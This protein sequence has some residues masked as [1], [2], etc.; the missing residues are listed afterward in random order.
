LYSDSAVVVDFVNEQNWN[1]IKS[2][3]YFFLSI[4]FPVFAVLFT[5]RYWHIGDYTDQADV[6]AWMKDYISDDWWKRGGLRI[7]ISIAS[8]LACGIIM[9][10]AIWAVSRQG[11][12]NTESLDPRLVGGLLATCASVLAILW[13]I[14]VLGIKAAESAFARYVSQNVNYTSVIILKRVVKSKLELGFMLMLLLF[15]PVLYMLSQSITVITN[16]NETLVE[17]RLKELNFYTSCFFGAFPP[18]RLLRGPYEEDV[19]PSMQFM[20]PLQSAPRDGPYF[21]RDID[22]IKCDALIGTTLY[23]VGAVSMVL[24]FISYVWIYISHIELAIRELRS[25][26][27]M[28]PIYNL[29]EKITVEERYYARDFPFERRFARQ[30]FVE[31]RQQF[32]YLEDGVLWL[33]ETLYFIVRGVL[34]ITLLPIIVIYVP[35]KYY[36]KRLVVLCACYTR[37][38]APRTA[39]DEPEMTSRFVKNTDVINDTKLN[40]KSIREVQQSDHGLTYTYAVTVVVYRALVRLSRRLKRSWYQ[41]WLG[42][43]QSDVTFFFSNLWRELTGRNKSVKDEEGLTVGGDDNMPGIALH[44]WREGKSFTTRERALR[45]LNYRLAQEF[46][47]AKIEFVTDHTMSIT[48]FDQVI[49]NAGAFFLVCPFKLTRLNYAIVWPFELCLYAFLGVYTDYYHTWET[50][51]VILICISTSMIVLQYWVDP[52]SAHED[53]WIDWCGRVVILIVGLGLLLCAPVSEVHNFGDSKMGPLRDFFQQLFA[54]P[55]SMGFYLLMDSIMTASVLIFALS[56][57]KSIGVFRVLQTYIDGVRYAMHD[58]V[59]DY[60]ML[61]VEERQFGFENMNTGLPLLMQWDDILRSQ[62]RYAL[63]TW[64][65]VRPPDLMTWSEKLII[66]KWAALFNLTVPKMRTT[67]GLSLLHTAMYSGDIAATRYLIYWYP[68]MLFLEDSQRDT[69]LSIGLK[70]CSFYLIMFSALNN[71][72][73][74][75]GTSFSDEDL[76]TYYPEAEAL[77]DML[78]EYGE[79]V[80]EKT[81]VYTLTA[82]DLEKMRAT[83]HFQERRPGYKDPHVSHPIMRPRVTFERGFGNG[84]QA[85]R[86]DPKEFDSVGIQGPVQMKELSS[87]ELR[88]HR[89]RMELLA[90]NPNYIMRYPEDSKSNDFESGV[91][92]CWEVLDVVVPEQTI[93]NDEY[94]PDEDADFD[95]KDL[96]YAVEADAEINSV[97]DAMAIP[98]GHEALLRA[99]WGAE[100]TESKKGANMFVSAPSGGDRKLAY[101]SS[102]PAPPRA[103]RS[104]EDPSRGAGVMIALKFWDS[105]KT[106]AD[107]NKTLRMKLCNFTDMFMADAVAS[108]CRTLTWK[109]AS[110]TELNKMSSVLQGIVAQNLAECFNLNPPKGFA[111]FNEWSSGRIKEVGSDPGTTA[112]YVKTSDT[113]NND[114]GFLK[115]VGQLVRRLRSGALP[116]EAFNDRI[117]MYLAEAYVASRTKLDLTG[118][119]MSTHARIAWRGITRAL[120]R[121]YNSFVVPSLFSDAKCIVLLQL[122]LRRNELDDGDAVLLGDIIVHQKQL[123]YIDVSEN[124]IGSR[125]MSWLCSCMKEHAS[126]KTFRIDHNRVGPACGRDV[127]L[128]LNRSTTIETLSMSHNRMGDL[129]RYP[130]MMTRER[131]LSAAPDIFLGVKRNKSLISLDLSYNYLGPS[132]ANSAPAAVIK[133]PKLQFLNLAGNAIGPLKGP[134]LLWALAG[135]AGGQKEFDA[136]GGMAGLLAAK[137]A[138]LKDNFDGIDK[139]KQPAFVKVPKVMSARSNLS[140]TSNAFSKSVTDDMSEDFGQQYVARLMEL[141]LSDNQ[142]GAV[143]GVA[144]GSFVKACPALTALDVSK[145]ALGADGCQAFADSLCELYLVEAAKDKRK[146]E[147]DSLIIQGKLPPRS[148]YTVKYQPLTRADVKRIEYPKRPP[149]L[150]HL[151]ISRNNMLPTTLINIMECLM[152]PFC[153]VTNLDISGNNLGE[154]PSVSNEDMVHAAQS[155]RTALTCNSV[156]Y[157]LNVTEMSLKPVHSVSV[158]GGFSCCQYVCEFRLNNVFFDEPTCLQLATTI[159]VCRSLRHLE[160]RNGMMGA[161]GGNLICAQVEKSYEYLEYVDLTGNGIGYTAMLPI[162]RGLANPKCA[163]KALL[164]GSNDISDEGG[165]LIAKSL[166]FNSTLSHLD[167]SHNMLGPEF[168]DAMSVV[169]RPL[170]IDGQNVTICKL[171]KV[172]LNDNPGIKGRGARSL[173]SAFANE[174]VYH[175]ELS[176]I[177]AGPRAGWLIGRVLRRVTVSWE[178]LDFSQN[179]LSRAGLNEIFWAMRQNRRLITLKLGGNE[180]GPILASDED[181]LGDHGIGLPRVIRENLILRYLD[182]SYNGI[183]SEGAINIF[184]A[185]EDNFTIM[186]FSIRGNLLDDGVANALSD[187]LLRND[188]IRE[189]DIGDN[190]LSY[191]CCLSLAEGLTANRAIHTL[192]ADRNELGAAGSLVIEQFY[193][194]LLKNTTL[195]YL[196]MDRNRLGPEW[197]VQFASAIARNNTLIQ[198]SL[199]NNRLDTRAGEALLNAYKYNK[200][201]IE[202]AISSEEVGY[203]CFARFKEM[204]DSKRAA[205]A[206]VSIED[207]TFVDAPISSEMH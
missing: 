186:R 67:L 173:I 43:R 205:T 142:L 88:T 140:G 76:Y 107:I 118:Q 86:R 109:I 101:P 28:E 119:C 170:I 90:R 23:T 85:D 50:R 127:A 143:T 116:A 59:V 65:D 75:D 187:M 63:I 39:D 15:L 18:Y 45:R 131:V 38:D 110:Y 158:V 70:E 153:G 148:V 192:H 197:G 97:E 149:N 35:V 136:S 46:V 202:I 207:E 14:G 190:K 17:P 141:N 40:L 179:R 121:K 49:D 26:R 7:A 204:Y 47:S 72:I 169:A 167:L 168:A 104:A 183:S 6:R 206:A 180:G 166:E 66:A 171:K 11:N 176:N 79:F 124:R 32:W 154:A 160:V 37:K 4:F 178:Y 83:Y 69:P 33:C 41:T 161:K 89:S 31:L 81:E 198:L 199:R 78:L 58:K 22:V 92:A 111:S 20:S 194:M 57:F 182:L 71:G 184:S 53:K 196:D 188:I 103:A 99:T 120:R 68:E 132:I 12:L 98:M 100:L 189:L 106:M 191:G 105:K 114:N 123:V 152:M 93:D 48:V 9:L 5:L 102:A 60:L 175:L 113:E 135:R 95:D 203:M 157:R 115:R 125:G 162:T 87:S 34:T 159:E 138:K 73:M 84:S 163:M 2:L 185:L 151:N 64:P 44:I 94:G 145:N 134:T 130:N 137:E 195:R 42:K 54:D 19:C 117:V 13:I 51:V 147:E 146:K 200:T 8:C 16:W 129:V 128:W 80:P 21:Y 177:G 30:V 1:S 29:V 174:H 56:I 25:S 172:V 77:R 122:I 96:K 144:L 139:P 61:K 108:K 112:N 52:Y 3:S 55:S 74:D 165:A 181:M 10:F 164:F 156:M 150:I 24:F 201:I 62:R 193:R 91:A 155:I 126:I 36:M 27:W 133:H 82:M